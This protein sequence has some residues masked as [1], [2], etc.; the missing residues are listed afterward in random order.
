MIRRHLRYW[1]SL[2]A[3][4]I[5]A[6]PRLKQMILALVDAM[7]SG[8]EVK[9][10]RMIAPR[11]QGALLGSMG[12]D[13]Q[14]Q[15]EHR[16][17]RDL[18]TVTSRIEP[19]VAADKPSLAY[20]SPLP[21]E[22]TG[23]SNY[24][25]ALLPHLA[26]H[27]R[28]T[29]IVNQ[30]AVDERPELAGIAVESLDW[31]Q[32]RAD[33]FDRI[34][35]HIGNA[36]FHG[37]M[38]NA[39]TRWPGVVMLH[40]F[41]LGHVVG[42]L[43]NLNP[44]YQ[45]KCL[46]EGWGFSALADCQDKA[47]PEDIIWQYPLNAEVLDNALGMIVH[48]AYSQTLAGLYFGDALRQQWHIIPHLK[49]PAEDTDKL[50]AR[51]QLGLPEDAF[52]VCSFGH[53]TPTKLHLNILQAW[54]DSQLHSDSQCWLVFVGEVATG[55]H[56]E[57]INKLLTKLKNPRIRITGW[58]DNA[59]FDGYLAAADAAIQLRSKSRGETSGAVIDCLNHGLAT[60]VNAHGT[61]VDLAEDS[62]L[63]LPDRFAD[64]ELVA[65]LDRVCRDHDFRHSLGDRSRA[66]IRRDHDP[67]TCAS[68]YAE[69]I[70]A[71]YRT[72]QPY[73]AMLAEHRDAQHDPAVRSELGE[74]ILSSPDAAYLKPLHQRQLLVD[75]S[76]MVHTDLRTG[77]ERVVR[78][79]LLELIKSPPTG[80]RVE[81][82]YLHQGKTGWNYHHAR[83]YGGAL[84]GLNQ[85]PLADEKVDFSANDILY[86]PDL[87]AHATLQAQSEG[88]FE[89]IRE[90]GVNVHVLIHDLLPIT[91]P[92]CFPP[93]AQ[94]NHQ[95]WLEA[96]S[97]IADQ[98]ICI[99]NAVADEYRTWLG[100]N[101]GIPRPA[102]ITVNHHGADIS[103]SKPTRGI[104]RQGRK[105]LRQLA[106]APTFVTVGTVEPRK[107]HLEILDAF[108][109]LWQS[110]QDVN[111]VIVGKEGWKDLPEEQ[112]R[113]IPQLVKRLDWHGQRNKKL[114]WL[115]SIS[116]EYLEAIYAASSCLIA[117][118]LDEGFGLPLI[119]AAQHRLP[120]V[121]RDI[122]VFRE[123]AGDAAY[124]FSA[125]RPLA[126]V[127]DQWLTERQQ[128]TVRNSANLPV[129][130]WKEN[131]ATLKTLLLNANSGCD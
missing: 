53:I 78:A 112:R 27:Y 19:A 122:P 68:A 47:S 44:G 119:E 51:R 131:V 58:A 69:A 120:I 20:F 45:Q 103:A 63:M 123:V 72:R 6:R 49:E 50:Q 105:I 75:V 73:E 118:S 98:I 117:A 59:T 114:F 29:V 93:G 86:M 102:T 130:T 60:I 106:S 125:D 8:L 92:D 129:R 80:Y 88:L 109:Q 65:A 108:D 84:L 36:P 3:R 40:D 101:P 21:P 67:A 66:T 4:W 124:Y 70:E 42:H 33:Q 30:E 23:I 54:Q 100:A 107:A 96:I 61:M 11:N 46:Y 14:S 116:D 79:Q 127:L 37:H 99:S 71:C 115:Q 39:L 12:I 24:S 126:T 5:V 10:R 34:L 85:L 121:A 82:V 26:A 13:E 64:A 32:H 52:V 57:Q 17:S 81:P 111:L 104:P 87:N 74:N 1:L 89:Q 110:G 55:R 25:L 97:A 90:R 38:F 62:V 76:A 41:F 128:G 56:G 77:I 31:F 94:A 95:R 22:R 35:Y 15:L 18:A 7:P 43:N 16:L 9:L 91:L 83:A 28:I 113:S 48:S 2:V